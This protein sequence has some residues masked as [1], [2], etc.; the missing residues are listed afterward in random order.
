MYFY[1]HYFKNNCKAPQNNYLDGGYIRNKLLLL[2]L[3]CQQFL[4]D[5]RAIT[6]GIFLFHFLV[7]NSPYVVCLTD[8]LYVT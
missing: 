3:I 8:V 5:H 2:L 4:T 1:Y 7:I 6:L